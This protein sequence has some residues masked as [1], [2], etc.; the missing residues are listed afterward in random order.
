MH[1]IAII[2]LLALSA[3][4][5]EPPFSPAV[6]QEIDQ[7]ST[8]PSL[9][10]SSQ[11]LAG[12]TPA[13]LA[14]FLASASTSTTNNSQPNPIAKT[15]PNM[16]TG[17]IN[18]SFVV[19][20]LDYSVARTIIPRKYGILKQSIKTVLP[21]FPEDKYPL[22]LSTQ[23]DHSVQTFGVSIPDFSSSQFRFP[24]ID[25]LGDNYST[26][27]YI[28]TLF[29]SDNA[30]AVAGSE[31]YAEDAIASTFNP[32]HDPYAFV[33]GD[34]SGSVYFDVF[35]V[36]SSGPAVLNTTYRPHWGRYGEIGEYPLS[37]YTN[38]T[39]Q[40][41]FGC[42]NNTT[43]LLTCD[44]MI[45]FFHTPITTSPFP[46]LGISGSVSLAP[47]SKS[48]V[49]IFPHGFKFQNVKGIKLDV[50][51]LENNYRDCRSLQGFQ[52]MGV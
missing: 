45:R 37:F 39:N 29:I 22:I 38:I 18:G 40:P 1:P 32:P 7:L 4:A 27:S 42:A 25:L 35:R 49:T 33:P 3:Y 31:A 5:L 50:A 23:I 34:R 47:F 28:P 14:A 6:I 19:L 26:F 43:C 20:P 11:L 46:P 15:F 17:T 10:N 30:I 12:L 24:F 8:L 9:I 2:S 44:N 21:F 36:N 51:F 13:E 48:G 41:T 52:Y 16:T